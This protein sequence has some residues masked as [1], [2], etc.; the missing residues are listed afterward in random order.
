M[1]F[2]LCCTLREEAERANTS[3]TGGRRDWKYP[4]N[5]N[6]LTNT[7]PP[8]NRNTNQLQLP[9]Q[10]LDMQ[11]TGV[12]RWFGTD[13]AG[14]WRNRS[15]WQVMVRWTIKAKKLFS[16]N[17]DSPQFK[18]VF[19]LLLTFTRW[20]HEKGVAHSSSVTHHISSFNYNVRS[21]RLVSRSNSLQHTLLYCIGDHA[22]RKNCVAS[23]GKRM[24]FNMFVT[25]KASFQP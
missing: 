21:P 16:N 4:L 20:P 13:A 7:E 24:Q 25:W 17:L 8:N 2:S 5:V 3:A 6:V 12:S 9:S 19:F 11:A 1:K 14:I 23:I 22:E 15:W 18:I 10:G